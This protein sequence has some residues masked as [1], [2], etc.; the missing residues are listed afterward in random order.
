MNGFKICSGICLFL[1]AA[2]EPLRQRVVES[3]NGSQWL[4]LFFNGKDFP[5]AEA[6]EAPEITPT[7]HILTTD[8]F[9]TAR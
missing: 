7:K 8:N 3:D 1:I 2:F 4:R 5:V 9:K 6:L